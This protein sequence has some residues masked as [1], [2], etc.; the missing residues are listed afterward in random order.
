[1]KCPN[2]EYIDIF[3]PM[4]LMLTMSCLQQCQ[5]LHTIVGLECFSVD[6]SIIAAIVSFTE[7]VNCKILYSPGK[8]SEI[9]IQLLRNKPTFERVNFP[10][11][12]LLDSVPH[13]DITGLN[14]QQKINDTTPTASPSLCTSQLFSDS[15]SMTVFEPTGQVSVAALT[16]VLTDHPTLVILDFTECELDNVDATIEIIVQATCGSNIAR[17]G[18]GNQKQI[19][20]SGIKLLKNL[21]GLRELV[22]ANTSTT[23]SSPTGNESKK[24][25]I[26]D[27]ALVEAS[28]GWSRLEVLELDGSPIVAT[29]LTQIVRNCTSLRSL[30][31]CGCINT[32]D[33]DL[34]EINKPGLKVRK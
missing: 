26:T 33:E 23:L 17:L 2:L 1:M 22:L 8:I 30:S 27:E 28:T 9:G 4:D 15:W 21:S 6:D 18:L 24:T 34:S 3:P 12:L 29:N 20:D 31:I 32:K 11:D 5:K 7:L 16:R 19:T 10:V 13:T 25:N 14:M